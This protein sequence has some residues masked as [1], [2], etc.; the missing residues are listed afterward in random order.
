[1]VNTRQLSAKQF[2]VLTNWL[3]TKKI[4]LMN[5]LED[6]NI[7]LNAVASSMK[8]INKRFATTSVYTAHNNFALKLKNWDNFNLLVLRK[9]GVSVTRKQL[10]DLAKS[11]AYALY[12]LLYQVM[13]AERRGFKM[14]TPRR[15]E[16]LKPNDNQ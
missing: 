6:G 16:S 4:N 14:F 1:M 12:Y 15:S 2:E 3:E 13:C 10:E 11:E 5:S 7:D 8:L 9:M